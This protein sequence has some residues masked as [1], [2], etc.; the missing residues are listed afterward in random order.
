MSKSTIPICG[1]ELIT[2]NSLALRVRFISAYRERR[3]PMSWDPFAGSTAAVSPTVFIP[4]GA[5]NSV[6]GLIWGIAAET[7]RCVGTKLTRHGIA[8]CLATGHKTL[9]TGREGNYVGRLCKVR[10]ARRVGNE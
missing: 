7:T 3:K 4:R 8:T 1:A 9:S 10:L 2:T 6:G 5:T